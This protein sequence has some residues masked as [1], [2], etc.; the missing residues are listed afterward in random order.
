MAMTD[1]KEIQDHSALNVVRPCT[2]STLPC[3]TS[4]FCITN[5]VNKT[6]LYIMFFLALDTVLVTGNNS[7][8]QM[9]EPSI[10]F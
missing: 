10:L 9:Q 7:T 2:F 3:I 5:M 6:V 8:T 4:K 1:A